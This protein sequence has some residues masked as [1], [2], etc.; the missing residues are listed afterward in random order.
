VRNVTQ[1]SLRTVVSCVSQD[2]ILFNATIRFNLT[3]GAREATDEQLA[4]ACRIAKVDAY[5]GQ[6][7]MG[8]DTMVGE[9]GLRL[10]GGEKQ[11]I[12]IARAVLRDPAV[13]VLDEATSSLD[14]ETESTVQAALVDAA[15]GRCTLSIAHRLSTIVN[16]DEIIVLKAGVAVERGSHEELLESVNGL[17]AGLWAK[18]CSKAVDRAVG[19]EPWPYESQ[20][21]VSPVGPD[22]ASPARQRGSTRGARSK[23]E[24]DEEEQALRQALQRIEEERARM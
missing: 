15:R 13:L 3:Y 2:T 22:A 17:Y 14:T 1:H 16:C 9:R 5:I 4:A 20:S 24:L 10:S 8:F 21:Y 18:Q 23:R 6:R 11:R 12:G 7:E 19:G